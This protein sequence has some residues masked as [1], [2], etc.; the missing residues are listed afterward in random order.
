MKQKIIKK[1]EKLTV[2]KEVAQG[3][4]VVDHL[5]F[6]DVGTEVVMEKDQ[7]EEEMGPEG[8]ECLM[9]AL[10]HGVEVAEDV[11]VDLVLEHSKIDNLP[12]FQSLLILGHQLNLKNNKIVSKLVR[13]FYSK[14][15]ISA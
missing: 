9:V 12:V 3:Y 11:E 10:R 5:D 14:V 7:V 15:S 2:V 13:K 4:E 1:T 6:E 8:V